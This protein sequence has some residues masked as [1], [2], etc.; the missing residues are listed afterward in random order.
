M[1]VII[2]WV[3]ILIR[4][5]SSSSDHIL[6]GLSHSSL[7]SQIISD[8]IFRMFADLPKPKNDPFWVQLKRQ[9]WKIKAWMALMG[10][11]VIVPVVIAATHR[12]W[13]W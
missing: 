8:L 11:L 3:V 4:Y 1:L 2:G 10:G 7:R 12:N 5:V 9:A 13:P 6:I